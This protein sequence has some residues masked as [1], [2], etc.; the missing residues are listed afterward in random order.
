[1]AN[2]YPFLI[3]VLVTTFTPGPNNI[4]AMTNAMRDGY[5]RTLNFLLGVFAGFLV[6]MLLCGLLNVVL[7]S[8]L[9]QMQLWLNI[10]GVIYLV[11]L[12]VHTILSKPV[13][14]GSD[15]H[16]PLK[17][18]LN[19]FKAGVWMQFLNLKL[20]LY[21]ITVFSMFITPVFQHPVSV[22][23]FAPVL[24]LIGLIATAC[25]ALGG[26][27]FRRFY[28]KYY[29]LFNLAMGGL[30]LYTAIHGLLSSLH[31]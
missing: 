9:P 16:Q 28:Q 6:V 10:L 5:R 18:D 19:T 24:A 1:M 25:W 15:E 31:F 21:G 2:F 4:M 20:I 14:G 7:V 22:S 27:I 13:A 29:R 3:Y 11:Y 30:L 17:T 12:A 8:L 23:L 26:S